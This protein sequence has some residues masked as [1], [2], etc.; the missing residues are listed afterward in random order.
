[1]AAGSVAAGLA[2]C[3]VTVTPS[4]SGTGSP[5]PSASPARATPSPAGASAP[6]AGA[7]PVSPSPTADP[8]ALR[9][10]IARILVVGFRGL[11]IH[12]GDPIT[13]ALAAG[14]GGVILFD[15]D[16]IT[17]GQRNIAS[18]KQLAALTASLRAAAPGPLLIALDQEGGKVSRLNPAMG[19]PATRTQATIGATD[20]PAVADA[21]GLAMGRTMTSAGVNLDLAPV[22]DVNVNP[23][24]PAIG[25]LG[26]SYSADPAVV[27][28]MAEAEI[29]GLHAAGVRSAI[30]HFPGLG[31]A[32]ANT[33]FAVVDVTK[34]WNRKE[35][36]PYETLIGAQLPDAIMSGNILNRTLDPT[37]PASLSAATVTGLLRGQLGWKGV[38]VTDDLGAVAI[39]SRFSRAEAVAL[40]IEAGNDLLLFANQATYVP[41]LATRLVDTIAGF[42]ASGRISEARIDESV[43]RL[44]A[45]AGP[46]LLS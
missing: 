2:A 27:A 12:E 1:M 32:S 3:G 6:P 25:A 14:L 13:A 44:E 20:D 45:I 7:T 8:A 34:T 16:Q 37:H 33:D 43:S 10:K 31:S 39:T 30:K 42:V 36:E 38:V 18:P 41:D 29:G 28:A 22:V 40:A 46:P 4:P 21:A 24:N 26:R 19:F 5:A 15:R 35:L 9:A 11:Q 17:G 23:T